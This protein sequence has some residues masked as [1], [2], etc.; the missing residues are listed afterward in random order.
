LRRVAEAKKL[1]PDPLQVDGTPETPRIKLKMSTDVPPITGKLTLKMPGQSSDT[2]S[3]AYGQPSN[4]TNHEPSGQQREMI[5]AGSADQDIIGTS[6]RA[7]SLRRHFDS[8]RSSVTTTTA[9]EQPSTSL[10]SRGL[11]GSIKNETPVSISTSQAPLNVA[12]DT[13]ADINQYD[14]TRKLP[15]SDMCS[16]Q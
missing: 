3:K 5:R 13:S 14:D 4:T 7:R 1:V 2:L 10:G 6:P 11:F 15:L 8:P 12:F 16:S 9:S